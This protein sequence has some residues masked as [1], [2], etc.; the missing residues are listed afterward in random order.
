MMDD[1]HEE[2]TDN[3]GGS[4]GDDRRLQIILTLIGAGATIVAAI[5]AGVFTVLPALRNEPPP[6]PTI[7][8]PAPASFSVEIDGPDRALLGEA[9]YFTILSDT[10]DRVEWAIAGFGEDTID[11]FRQTDQIFVEPSDAG[12]VGEWFILVVTAYNR[13]GE[14]ASARH[15]FQIVSAGE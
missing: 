15:R 6:Q 10:A 11:P 7:A 5:I 8:M 3:A 4:G 12:R 13:D 1:E 2:I 14:S 9:T